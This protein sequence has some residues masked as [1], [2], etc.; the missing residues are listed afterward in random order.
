[1]SSLLQPINNLLC[2]NVKFDWNGK[3][4][5]SFKAVKKRMQENTVLCHFDPKLPIVLA[6]DASAY[7]VGAVLSHIMP[8]GTERP[9]QFASQSLSKT[10]RKY[11]QIDKEAYGIIFGVKKFFQFLYGRRFTLQTDHQPLI[12]IFSPSKSIPSLSAMRMRHYSLYSQSFVYDIKYRNTTKIHGNADAMSRLPCN[13][14]SIKEYLE[15][16]DVFEIQQIE[17][18]PVTVLDVARETASEIVLANLLS[19]IETGDI[20]NSSERF[21]ISQDEFSI[22]SSCLMRGTRVIIPTLLRKQVLE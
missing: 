1:M 15:P 19:K 16:G 6:T 3:C 8:D 20:L 22:Q 14:E 4:E 13:S 12:Q 17:T 2:N 21:N 11:S 5:E 7:A 9:I 10:Q 18:L